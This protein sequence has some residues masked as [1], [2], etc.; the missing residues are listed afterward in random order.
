M[1]W[2]KYSS[3][4]ASQ[5]ARGSWVRVSIP[6]VLHNKAG[7][8]IWWICIWHSVKL[9]GYAIKYSSVVVTAAYPGA[10]CYLG[11]PSQT[12]PKPK[13][14]EAKST[15][16]LSLRRPTAPKSCPEHDSITVVL[17]AKSQ[18]DRTIET[19]VAD[20]RV[21]DGHPTLHSSPGSSMD[22][23]PR[24]FCSLVGCTAI[25]SERHCVAHVDIIGPNVL[26]PDVHFS[27]SVICN[28]HIACRQG[29]IIWCFFKAL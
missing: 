18:N 10:L 23:A 9:R 8:R 20:E 5:P 7:T 4:F 27:K 2:Q 14:R 28:S 1:P 16:N 13:S 21:P 11:H 6:I 15:H 3:L 22:Y 19:D 29:V 25:R 12:H 26:K 17:R 24:T